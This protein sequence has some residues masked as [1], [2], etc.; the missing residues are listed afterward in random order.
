MICTRIFLSPGILAIEYEAVSV[1]LEK[2][3][4]SKY[5]KM[6]PVCHLLIKSK[7][8]LN[9]FV[10]VK[11]VI[12]HQL[13]CMITFKCLPQNYF[14][15]IQSLFLEQKESTERTMLLANNHDPVDFMLDLS[16]PSH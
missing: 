15:F 2:R 5:A 13:P 16:T 12:F 8:K 10:H 3:F 11:S 6:L 14:Q 4:P 1:S 9:M 7:A